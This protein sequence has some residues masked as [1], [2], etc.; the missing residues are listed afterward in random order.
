MSARASRSKR[1]KAAPQ[2]Q[3]VLS[4]RM[5][6]MNL[7]LQVRTRLAV[8]PAIPRQPIPNEPRWPALIYLRP[9]EDQD[10]IR[11]DQCRKDREQGD[12]LPP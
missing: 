4:T 3:L 12:L 10:R 9:E 2:G 5:V 8:I 11:H 7:V 6:E 1:T